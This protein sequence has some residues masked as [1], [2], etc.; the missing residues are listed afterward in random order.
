MIKFEI[1][2]IPCSISMELEGL[3]QHAAFFI[4]A[5]L[6]YP[7]LKESVLLVSQ[8]LGTEDGSFTDAEQGGFSSFQL[9]ALVLYF[10]DVS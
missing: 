9:W 2:G 5:C 4:K 7:A 1:S 6:D 8:I 3:D 10:F